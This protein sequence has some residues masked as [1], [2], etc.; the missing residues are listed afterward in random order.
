ML[1]IEISVGL[2]MPA[3]VAIVVELCNPPALVFKGVNSRTDL[4]PS[5]KADVQNVL[6]AVGSETYSEIN[7]KNTEKYR[8]KLNICA[9]E[10]LSQAQIIGLVRI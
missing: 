8:I 5:F 6:R 1:I 7:W 9:L 3:N 4:A 10:M 2:P